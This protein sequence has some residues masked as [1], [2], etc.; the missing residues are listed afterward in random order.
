VTALLKE[1]KQRRDTEA[2][3]RKDLFKVTKIVDSEVTVQPHS[4][5]IPQSSERLTP[6]ESPFL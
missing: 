5:P 6:N 3:A 2:W 1:R 4:F